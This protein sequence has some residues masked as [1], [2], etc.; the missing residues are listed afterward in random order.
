MQL[1][2]G[3]LNQD[4]ELESKCFQSFSLVHLP[5]FCLGLVELHFYNYITTFCNVLYV[6][7]RA[8]ADFVKVQKLSGMIIRLVNNGI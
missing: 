5:L 3:I 6:S 8:S 7:L 2:K 4:E 1:L